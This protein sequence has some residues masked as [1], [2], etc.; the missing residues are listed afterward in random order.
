MNAILFVPSSRGYSHVWSVSRLKKDQL[1]YNYTGLI[2]GKWSASK[3]V[4]IYYK[5]GYQ[6]WGL[7][8][9]IRLGQG[10]HQGIGE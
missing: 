2:Y 8:L 7:G 9:T 5:V 6:S 1:E 10:G 4:M 3:S